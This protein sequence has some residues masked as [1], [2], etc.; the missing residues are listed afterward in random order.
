M[1]AY[2]DE[3]KREAVRLLDVEKYTLKEASEA[4]GV[5]TN[6]LCNWRKKYGGSA[7]KDCFDTE[8]EFQFYTVTKSERIR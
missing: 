2:S 6:T 8:R 7:P 4:L 1:K 5:S 3:F